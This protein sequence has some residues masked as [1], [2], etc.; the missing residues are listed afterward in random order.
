[1]PQPAKRRT[2]G[3]SFEGGFVFKSPEKG[4]LDRWKGF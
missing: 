2:I 1:M 4:S 3:Q